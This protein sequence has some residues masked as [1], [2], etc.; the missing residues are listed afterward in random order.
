MGWFNRTPEEEELMKGPLSGYSPFFP[1]NQDANI[2]FNRARQAPL[3]AA[4]QAGMSE[5][6]H[7]DMMVWKNRERERMLRFREDLARQEQAKLMA[8][9]RIAEVARNNA[10][11]YAELGGDEGR[12]AS[13]H[14]QWANSVGYKPNAVGF[15]GPLSTPIITSRPV[16]AEEVPMI[17]YSPTSVP[18]GDVPVN[19][20]WNVNLRF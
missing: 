7:A 17:R 13:E 6:D 15:S 11:G 16:S 20:W 8:E 18:K 5:A 4:Q 10:M 12:Q 19:D 9:A 2:S 14:A 1:W 3:T